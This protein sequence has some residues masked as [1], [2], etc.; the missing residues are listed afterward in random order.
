[1]TYA[2]LKDAVARLGFEP[3]LEDEAAL[4]PALSRA[5][6]TVY[7][8][9][10]TEAVA[11]IARPRYTGRLVLESMEHTPGE[12]EVYALDGRAYSLLLSGKGSYTLRTGGSTVTE[13]F[14]SPLLPV[15]GILGD[16]SEISFSG[17]YSYTVLSLAVYPTLRSGRPSDIPL[18]TERNTLDL[19]G[20]IPDLLSVTGT[21]KDIYGKEIRGARLRGSVLELPEGYCGELIVSYC[22]TPRIPSGMDPEERLDLPPEC[23]ELLPL[24]VASYVW[25]EDS[26]EKAQ[27]YL[28]LYKDGIATLRSLISRKG[29]GEYLTDGWA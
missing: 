2:N 25:L 22:R 15:R 23:E 6:Y 5:L 13:S 24:L 10:P 16:R 3:E 20:A 17:D 4:A 29:V 27:Y 28:S 26:P 12:R 1:M 8:D 14:D 7:T 21:P 9:R 19:A 11:R 18:Y